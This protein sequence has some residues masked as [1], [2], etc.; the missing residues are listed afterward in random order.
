MNKKKI[1]LLAFLIVL[2]SISFILSFL[3]LP[4]P[5]ALAEE[6]KKASV[7]VNGGLSVANFTFSTRNLIGSSSSTIGVAVGVDFMYDVIEYISLGAG[8]MYINKG[9]E[10]TATVR[11][12]GRTLPAYAISTFDYLAIPILVHFH[13]NIT[14]DIPTFRPFALFSLEPSFLLSAKTGYRIRKSEIEKT[15]EGIPE[16]IIDDLEEFDFGIGFGAGI[17]VLSSPNFFLLA[18]VEY[19][20]GLTNITKSGKG[21]MKNRAFVILLG[22]FSP[23]F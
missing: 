8:L 6:D 7:G 21:E 19:I 3:I 18:Q 23:I 20:L 1:K 10:F 14:E 9:G 15:G 2:G 12:N 16:D 4:H 22:F 17:K 11:D 5:R 13:D